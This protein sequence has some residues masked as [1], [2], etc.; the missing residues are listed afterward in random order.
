MT[1]SRARLAAI[2][3]GTNTIRLLIADVADQKITE[4][5]R[6]MYTNR[7][8][9][10]LGATGQISAESL[11][12]TRSAL[13]EF[14]AAI[15]EFGPQAVRMVA[16]SASRDASNRSDFVRLAE[17]IVGVAPE[18]ITGDQE[19]ALSF[20]G[21]TSGLGDAVC[22]LVIDIGGGSTEFVI[23]DTVV[24]SSR[25]TDVGCVRLTEQ[26]FK[27]DPPT[28]DQLA[29]A[30]AAVT[31]AIAQARSQVDFD[32]ALE[33]VGVAGTITTM[34]AIAL[35]IETYDSKAIHRSTIKASEIRDI[36]SKLTTLGHDERAA[37]PTMHPGRVDVIAAGAVILEAVV[38]EL[39][40][41]SVIASE[42]DILHGIVLSIVS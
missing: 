35:G 8:G 19:A 14:R 22:R 5:C 41:D 2:D 4:V 3:C 20:A 21:A 9:Q 23:G 42:T 32:S 7:L 36:A 1:A 13:I 39:G 29:H 11:Q 25:S 12:R 28:P 10:G 31:A 15:D 18:V 37:I 16:T 33:V 6:S 30:R 38:T 17:Q 34:T 26:Y 24:R 40:I 27:N